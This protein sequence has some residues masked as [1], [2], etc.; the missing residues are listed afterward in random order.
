MEYFGTESNLRNLILNTKKPLIIRNKIKSSIVNW[1]LYY[2][3]KIIKNE[4]LTFRCGK[5]KFTKEPQWESRCSTKVATFQEFINQSNSN[6]EE[7]WYFDYKYLRDWFSSNTE[8]KKNI[9]WSELG[10]PEITVE[11]TTIWIGSKGAH[12]PCHIDTYGCNMVLQTFGSKLWLLFPPEENLRPSRVPYEESS[13]YSKINFFSPDISILKDIGHCYKVILN[14]GDV[15]IVPNRWWHYVENLEFA[16]SINTWLPLP[17]DNVEHIKECITAILVGGIIN[18]QEHNFKRFALNPNMIEGMVN[19]TDALNILKNKLT[20][21][22][23]G[24]GKLTE[25]ETKKIQ[26]FSESCDFIIGLEEL[27]GEDLKNFIKQ[28]SQ[29]FPIEKEDNIKN[30]YKDIS[31]FLE[32]VTDPEVVSLIAKKI[33]EKV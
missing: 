25:H 1:D 8:L 6:I 27:S 33:S 14:P 19:T 16:I 26:D 3:K 9:S 20:E 32:A 17:T 5:N 28:Q 22:Q 23:S 4:L 18:T 13:I 2:W 24:H 10:F 21:S 29:R 7:W 12:T 11:D 30:S 15:L 31:D